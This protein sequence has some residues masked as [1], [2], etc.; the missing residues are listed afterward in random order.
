MPAP[1]KSRLGNIFDGLTDLVA[2]PCFSADAE[3]DFVTR[4]LRQHSVLALP[5]AIVSPL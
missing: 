5:I 3:N 1:M 4:S 2:F